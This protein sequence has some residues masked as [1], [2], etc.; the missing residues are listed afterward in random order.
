MINKKLNIKSLNL[1]HLT[2]NVNSCLI[3]Q[4]GFRSGFANVR[5]DQPKN[6]SAIKG[7]SIFYNYFA[8]LKR[9]TFAKPHRL[10]V[11]IESL[12]SCFS[13]FGEIHRLF[14]GDLRLCWAANRHH[15][16][17]WCQCTQRLQGNRLMASMDYSHAWRHLFSGLSTEECRH[18]C[19]YRWWRVHSLSASVSFQLSSSLSL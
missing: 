1:R 5:K 13:V 10:Q 15:H 8:I 3:L 12:M 2:T 16:C 9:Q 18:H 11:Q 17:H 14:G 19:H 4:R 7:I 6:D